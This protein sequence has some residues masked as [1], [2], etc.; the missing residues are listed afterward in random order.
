ML[1]VTGSV[2]SQR[3]PQRVLVH[4]DAHGIAPLPVPE[5]RAILRGAEELIAS[6]GRTLLCKILKGSRDKDVLAHGLEKNPS[7][8]FYRELG[9]DEITARID[10]MILNGYLCL[11][12]FHRLPLLCYTDAGLQ[13]EIDM[14]TDEHLDELRRMA[15]DKIELQRLAFFNEMPR[16]TVRTLLDKVEATADRSLIPILQVWASGAYKKVRARI[17]GVIATLERGQV[18]PDERSL[19]NGVSP[20]D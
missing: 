4:L 16:Q 13:I 12:Y 6:G 20:S 2:M 3:H 9:A 10:W 7:W 19:T 15:S 18:S 17:H 11:E 8:A 5:I 14:V 1:D